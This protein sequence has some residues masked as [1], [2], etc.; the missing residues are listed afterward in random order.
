MILGIG[1]DAIEIER[2]VDWAN[3]TQES[4]KKTLTQDE[5]DYCLEIPAKAPERFAARFATKEAFF[6][7]FCQMTPEHN[8]PFL[9]ICQNTS[10]TQTQHGRPELVINWENI[11]EN[12]KIQDKRQNSKNPQIISHT[13][14]TH[15]QKT[16]TVIVILERL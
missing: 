3:M 6:K 9:T 2:F 4:L 12:S 16:A 11:L 5:I 8:I 1:I 14:I 15:T 10:V 7:A 13:S